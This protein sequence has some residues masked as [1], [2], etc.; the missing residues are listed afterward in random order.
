MDGYSSVDDRHSRGITVLQREEEAVFIA[1][2]AAVRPLEADDRLPLGH[3]DVQDSVPGC[4]GFAGQ[5]G[6]PVP[7]HRFDFPQV[8]AVQPLAVPDAVTLVEALADVLDADEVQA[9]AVQDADIDPAASQLVA[10]LS[11]D[12]GQQGHE[13]DHQS[14]DH[15]GNRK[16]PDRFHDAF[17]VSFSTYP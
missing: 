17:T 16:S 9:R 5:D 6:A 8:D 13:G 14:G 1:V 10:L 15:Q 11:G 7:E 3:G 2:E 4:P 12:A